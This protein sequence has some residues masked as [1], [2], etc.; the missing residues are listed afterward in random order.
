MSLSYPAFGG[1]FFQALSFLDITV[2]HFQL[3]ISNLECCTLA[4]LGAVFLVCVCFLV[5]CQGITKEQLS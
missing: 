4:L 2:P 5:L 3:T 1:F